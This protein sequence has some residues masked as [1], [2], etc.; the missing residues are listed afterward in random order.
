MLSTTNKDVVNW[1]MDEFYE[2]ANE[3]HD[4]ET[5]SYCTT[6]LTEFFLVG[7]CATSEEL[8]AIP[9]ELLWHFNEFP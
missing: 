1:Y 8:V 4:C 6:Y 9:N 5:N 3:A 7:F 2:I